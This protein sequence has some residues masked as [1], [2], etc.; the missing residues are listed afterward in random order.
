M[1]KIILFSVLLLAT[2]AASAQEYADG[3]G[4]GLG[5]EENL[6]G[7]SGASFVYDAGKFRIDALLGFDYESA[8]GNNNGSVTRFGIAGRF[9]WVLHRMER[10]DFSLGGGFGIVRESIGDGGPSETNILLEFAAQIRV[11]IAP[12]VALSGSLGVAVVTADNAVVVS[13]PVT[14]GGG[15]GSFGI[16]GELLGGFGATYYFR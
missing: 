6:G 15:D 9:F 12:N 7:L 13:G 14:S 4:P 5:I 2:G 11:F 10:A 3:H 16:G 8:A 1:S